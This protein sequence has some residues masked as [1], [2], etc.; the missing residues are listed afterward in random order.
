VLHWSLWGMTFSMSSSEMYHIFRDVY[1]KNVFTKTN[2]KFLIITLLLYFPFK[3][4]FFSVYKS[5]MGSPWKTWRIQRVWRIYFQSIHM[6]IKGLNIFDYF[7]SSVFNIH[8][9]EDGSKVYHFNFKLAAPSW[10]SYLGCA[11]WTTKLSSPQ[12][13]LVSPSGLFSF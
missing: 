7:V 4:L 5:N 9:L 8:F 1:V 6:Q 2:S 3:C 12:S 11:S 10:S 13:A